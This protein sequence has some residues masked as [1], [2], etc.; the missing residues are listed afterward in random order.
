MAGKK[1]EDL[2]GLSPEEIA[3]LSDDGDQVEN[4]VLDELATGDVPEDDP[5]DDPEDLD[6]EDPNE[7][8][9]DPADDPE[10]PAADPADDPEEPAAERQFQPDIA[11]APVENYVDRLAELNLAKETLRKQLTEGEIELEEYDR[12]K[13]EI[14]DQ[15]TDLRLQQNNYENEVARR[16][17]EG[18]QRW[19][20]EQDTFFGRKENA[21]YRENDLLGA[22]L[23]TAVRKL[24]TDPAN[25]N[26]TGGWFLEEADRQ[27]RAVFQGTKQPGD[28]P[29]K[30]PKPGARKPNL[31]DLPPT[32]KDIPPA[33]ETE[34]GD[35]EFAY[36]DKL[37]GADLERE[38][39]KISRDPV[40]EA[41]YLRS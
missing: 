36:L 32:L 27:V 2:S 13:D 39:A 5:D 15:I 17:S 40:K 22:A 35:S 34:T 23:D 8:P 7:D 14:V 41:R 11:V 38:L 12:K 18:Q 29:P 28:T 20:W 24:A 4:Q 1:D 19:Q 3:A 25:A 16:K 26:Q 37:S 33:A 9:A 21:I 10:D 30:D 6:P 31:K